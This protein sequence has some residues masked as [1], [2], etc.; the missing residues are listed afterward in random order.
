MDE[1]T[2]SMNQIQAISIILDEVG[3]LPGKN[4]SWSTLSEIPEFVILA[5]I[6]TSDMK[7]MSTEELELEVPQSL[8]MVLSNLAADNII[9]QS[10]NTYRW[11]LTAR[12][13]EKLSKLLENI[14]SSSPH[15]TSTEEVAETTSSIDLSLIASVLEGTPYV[16]EGALVSTSVEGEIIKLLLGTSKMSN[17]DFEGQVKEPLQISLALSNLQ[18]DSVIKQNSDYSW[19]LHPDLLQRYNEQRVKR[20]KEIASEIQNAEEQAKIKEGK[21]I[22]LDN[23]DYRYLI[24]AIKNTSYISGISPSQNLAD[25]P[26]FEVLALLYK[27]DSMTTGEL[28]LKSQT[29][30]SLSLALSNLKADRLI[31]SELDTW[32]LDRYLLGKIEEA[33]KRYSTSSK[34]KEEKAREDEEMSKIEHRNYITKQILSS[35]KERGITYSADERNAHAIPEIDVL[36]HLVE[37]GPLSTSELEVKINNSSSLSLVLSNLQADR[38]ITQDSKYRWVLDQIFSKEIQKTSSEEVKVV[39]KVIKDNT[40]QSTEALHEKE[41]LSE[42]L[43]LRKILFDK[44]IISSPSI[45]LSELYQRTDFEI[46]AIVLHNQPIETSEIE[47]LLSKQVLLSMELSNLAADNMIYYSESESK[48]RISPD[49]QS[50]I[51]KTMLDEQE[52]LTE[53][54]YNIEQDIEEEITPPKSKLSE[55]D[56]EL[57][58]ILKGKGYQLNDEMGLEK[59]KEIPEFY[60]FKLICKFGPIDLNNLTEMTNNQPG[61]TLTLSNLKADDLIIEE[62][63]KYLANPSV[64]RGIDYL[65]DIAYSQVEDNLDEGEKVE[66]KVLEEAPEEVKQSNDEIKV[67]LE[68]AKRRSEEQRKKE[69]EERTRLKPF[70]LATYN[71]GYISSTDLPHSANLQN[72]EYE[73]LYTIF[74]NDGSSSDLIKQNVKNCS[75]VMVSRTLN[76]LEADGVIDISDTGEVRLTSMF[77]NLLD[78]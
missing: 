73:V 69:I 32:Y 26:E 9:E 3:Y 68:E 44:H 18:A 53:L 33:K 49:L 8:A 35:L 66:E 21:L 65:K 2:L 45:S 62:N 70:I 10:S 11:C 16:N 7:S 20:Q 63:Y 52:I 72:T 76:R 43:K 24:E 60:I 37:N 39:G 23:P 64:I 4:L 38:I 75:P 27:H 61:L 30:T 78:S 19:S 12:T 59:V 36:F 54:S 34:M 15:Q 42:R 55:L 13:S 58:S 1:N 40:I 67:K 51:R 71:L 31:A 17:V 41:V 57:V 6:I 74:E 14:S 5:M 28:E 50:T 29:S 25:I 48:W 56:Q 22:K 47:A 46:L 77:R